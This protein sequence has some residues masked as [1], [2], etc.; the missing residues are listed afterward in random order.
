MENE[1][2]K[3]QINYHY[4]SIDMGLLPASVRPIG[5]IINNDGHGMENNLTT[6]TTANGSLQS[7]SSSFDGFTNNLAFLVPL[8]ICL[9]TLSLLTFFGNA[10]VVHAIRTERKLHTVR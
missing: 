7:S 4:N 8:S 3:N 1:Y 2:K 5:L 9:L 6:T 10:M